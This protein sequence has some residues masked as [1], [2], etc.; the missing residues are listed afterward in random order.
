[1]LQQVVVRYNHLEQI[2]IRLYKYVMHGKM[3]VHVIY[4][5]FSVLKE[6]N[7]ELTSKKIGEE[8]NE[9]DAMGIK[10]WVGLYLNKGECNNR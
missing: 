10:G 7:N 2:V 1:M 9:K 3:H 4:T 8:N 5:W 6:C